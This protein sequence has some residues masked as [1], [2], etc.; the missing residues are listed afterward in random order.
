MERDS[1]NLEECT[2]LFDVW[3]VTHLTSRLL[4]DHLRPLGLTGDEFGLY[5]LVHTFEPIA[6]GRIS[7]LTGM[8][9]TTVSGMIRRLTARGHLVQVPNPEDARSR[10]LRLSDDGRRVTA[11]AAGILV[12]ILPRLYGA[13]AAG[14]DAVRAALADLDNALRGM[15]D[16]A[17]RPYATP[18]AR[19][20]DD[21]P[22]SITYG[23]PRLTEAQEAEVRMFIDWLRTRD[24]GGPART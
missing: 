15:T 3:L 21:E 14:P 19:P 11:K 17:P 18:P 5:S 20:R 16:V 2:L 13:L 22:P 9:P 8:A 6:P 1:S 7:R 23:G 12:T 10:L 4:D 24:R